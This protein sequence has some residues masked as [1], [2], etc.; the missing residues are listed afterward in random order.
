MRAKLSDHSGELVRHAIAGGDRTGTGIAGD[1][2][3]F[4][5][6]GQ[7]ATDFLGAFRHVGK[8]DRL[9]AL[10]EIV[11]K[12][13]RSFREH[14]ALARRDLE[15]PM[16]G[17]VMVRVCDEGEAD[18]RIPESSLIILAPY[19]RAGDEPRH[20]VGAENPFPAVA[21]NID[22]NFVLV[23]QFKKAFRPVVM[24]RAGE[25]HIDPSIVICPAGGRRELPR[26][27]EREID[28]H[29]TP[30]ARLGEIDFADAAG[31][32]MQIEKRQGFSE[33]AP[34]R[35]AHVPERIVIGQATQHHAHVAQSHQGDRAD[36]NWFLSPKHVRFKAFSEGQNLLIK[37]GDRRAHEGAKPK[38]RRGAA[39][40]RHVWFGIHDLNVAPKLPENANM[41]RGVVT[42]RYSSDEE[43]AGSRLIWHVYPAVPEFVLRPHFKV[44]HGRG[45]SWFGG[46]R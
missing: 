46:G 1:P 15:T 21:P 42:R 30:R 10:D 22:G 9:L 3:P 23:P 37:L 26:R 17:V 25:R 6:V 12:H 2:L 13:V 45:A 40:T 32:D 31:N 8:V 29:Y 19:P 38:P 27:V 14:E 4:G 28:P 24:R 7:V 39:A 36:A 5:D 35:L 43:N 11:S 44:S 41:G 16:R 34:K 20:V 33:Q 18:A